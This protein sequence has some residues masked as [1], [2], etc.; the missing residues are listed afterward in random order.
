MKREQYACG[1]K[2][3]PFPVNLKIHSF[4][5]SSSACGV[6]LSCRGFYIR[7]IFFFMI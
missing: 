3:C 5:V 1:R 2:G 7:L 4:G 6:K